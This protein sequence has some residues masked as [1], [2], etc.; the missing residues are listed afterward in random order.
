MHPFARAAPHFIPVIA[1]HFQLCWFRHLYLSESKQVVEAC[2]A[3]DLLFDEPA[4]LLRTRFG[5]KPGK[6]RIALAGT[7]LAQAFDPADETV[8]LVRNIRAE[9]SDLPAPRF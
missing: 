3:G 9:F 4:H 1:G 2:L 7:G 5:A 6:Q 8:N